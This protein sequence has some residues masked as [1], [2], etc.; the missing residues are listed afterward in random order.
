MHTPEIQL[1]C[2]SIL[3]GNAFSFME[4]T[5]YKGNLVSLV[6]LILNAFSCFKSVMS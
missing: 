2:F 5:K 4:Q 3:F 1:L 6:S